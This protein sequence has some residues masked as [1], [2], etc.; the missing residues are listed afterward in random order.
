MAPGA[1]SNGVAATYQE[2][3]GQR[4]RK[5]L[6]KDAESVALSEQVS[7]LTPLPQDAQ[8]SADL[9]KRRQTAILELYE[10]ANIPN[11]WQKSEAFE[12]FKPSF[13]E[14]DL[15]HEEVQ[16]KFAYKDYVPGYFEEGW[17]QDHI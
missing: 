6:G 1:L 13:D 4:E 3:H 5:Y 12:V 8:H 10:A 9:L 17:V 14:P 16:K 15:T 7:G 2:Q 11:P